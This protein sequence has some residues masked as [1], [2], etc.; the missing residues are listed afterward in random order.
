MSA[1]SRIVNVALPDLL[2]TYDRPLFLHAMSVIL[3]GIQLG[4]SFHAATDSSEILT[5]EIPIGRPLFPRDVVG[6]ARAALRSIGRT[7]EPKEFS[8]NTG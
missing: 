4:T 3:P 8:E 6:A 5:A 1:Q 2:N 7:G